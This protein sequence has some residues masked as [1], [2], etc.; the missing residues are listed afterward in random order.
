M[1]VCTGL[2]PSEGGGG[3]AHTPH[4][5]FL[6][7]TNQSKSELVSCSKFIHLYNFLP[8]FPNFWVENDKNK[9]IELHFLIRLAIN[10]Q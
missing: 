3:V 9:L 4:F 7:M 6:E 10:Y 2:I 8:F 1:I 5:F